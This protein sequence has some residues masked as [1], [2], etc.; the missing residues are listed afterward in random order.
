VKRSGAISRCATLAALALVWALPATAAQAR[1]VTWAQGSWSWFGDP[2]AVQ[3]GGATFVGW[4][5][6]SG[7][8]T[9]GELDRRSGATRA[10]IVARVYHDDHSDPSIVVEPDGRLTVFWSG[11]KGAHMYYRTTVNPGDIATW[12]PV[13]T[14]QQSIRGPDGFTYPNPVLLPAEANRLYLFWRGADYSADFATRTPTGQWSATRELIRS[15]GQR[16][17]VK[18]ADN[19]SNLIALA[20]TNGH[21]RDVLTSVYYAAYRH[22]S[23]WRPGGTWIT[24]IDWGP[25]APREASLVY[26]AAKT[27]VPAWVWDVAIGRDGRPVIV[28]AT[29]PPHA[30]HVYWYARFNGRR[31]VSHEL[32]RAGGSISPGTIEQQYSGGVVLDHGNPST[33]YLS[34]QVHHGWQI[35]RWATPDGGSHWRRSIAV[36]AGG[37]DN[38]RPVVPRGYTGGPIGLLWLRG[39]YGTYTNYK[40]SIAFTS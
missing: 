1:I 3:V 6:W 38:V 33:V 32:T 21:P 30:Q 11:H 29:F 28:Y 9:V 36:P 17:Y 10:V 39:V 15:P 5:D 35:E 16:P 24:R 34:R 26:D 27:R 18:V 13:E 19:G 7:R 40:T 12:T 23:L 8:V 31:W 22:G 4:I 20:F 37:T 14:L 25:I 2:R